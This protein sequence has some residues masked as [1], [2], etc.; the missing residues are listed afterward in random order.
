MNQT[1]WESK[2]ETKNNSLGFLLS[3]T[4]SG[5]LILSTMQLWD[6]ITI[7]I[8]VIKK[9]NHQIF[10]VTLPKGSISMSI[11]Q[12]ENVGDILTTILKM[13]CMDLRVKC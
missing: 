7:A 1:N 9:S 10:S 6:W 3:L 5:T 11:I 12:N 8:F 13:A 2:L 4:L